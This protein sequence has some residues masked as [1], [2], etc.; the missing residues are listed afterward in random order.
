MK[1]NDKTEKP[2]LHSTCLWHVPLAVLWA[3]NLKKQQNAFLDK[4]SSHLF[5]K[6]CSGVLNSTHCLFIWG[7][8]QHCQYQYCNFQFSSLWVMH[9]VWLYHDKI[10]IHSVP[11]V[12]HIIHPLK[13][14]KLWMQYGIILTIFS[15]RF[16][17]GLQNGRQI[18]SAYAYSWLREFSMMTSA[19]LPLDFLKICSSS[20]YWLKIFFF[21][22]REN[23]SS[24]SPLQK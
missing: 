15:F 8:Q 4:V 17:K 6:Y 20:M 3:S 23:N 9:W 19:F 10:M 5:V 14:M 22:V 11:V 7:P 24:Y 13:T 21:R 16:V 1:S 18:L 12:F 2:K